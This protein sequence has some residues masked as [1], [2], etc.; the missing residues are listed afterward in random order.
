MVNYNGCN[1]ANLSA[2]RAVTREEASY[3]ISR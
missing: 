2:V 1:Q 3:A